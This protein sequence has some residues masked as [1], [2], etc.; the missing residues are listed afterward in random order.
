MLVVLR[1]PVAPC[2]EIGRTI[3]DVAELSLANDVVISCVFVAADAYEREQN[4]LMLNV[5]REGVLV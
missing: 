5:R 1:G 2:E 4:P 3:G